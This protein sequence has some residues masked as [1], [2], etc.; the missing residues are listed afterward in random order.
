MEV[1]LARKDVTSTILTASTLYGTLLYHIN[2]DAS[3]SYKTT[4]ISWILSAA[5]DRL[6]FRS[7]KK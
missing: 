6:D 7:G 2:T 1:H 5:A 3:F 4:T